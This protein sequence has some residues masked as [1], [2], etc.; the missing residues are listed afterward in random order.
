MR[1][2]LTIGLGLSG[3]AFAMSFGAW[4]VI[5]GADETHFAELQTRI[6]ERRAALTHRQD[7]SSERPF[8]RGSGQRLPPS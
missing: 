8:R 6:A 1:K 5:G 4:V 7:S 3:L 2:G